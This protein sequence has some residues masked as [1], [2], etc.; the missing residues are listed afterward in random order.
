MVAPIGIG[1]ALD[2][3]LGWTPWA[4]VGGAVFGFVGGLLHLVVMVNRHDA[5]EAQRKKSEK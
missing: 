2:Y 3:Y 4:T 1:I 5:E